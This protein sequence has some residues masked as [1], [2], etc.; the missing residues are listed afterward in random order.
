MS[1]V[2]VAYEARLGRGG[3]RPPPIGRRRRRRS[4][5][6]KLKTAIDRPSRLNIVYAAIKK[7]KK[8]VTAEGCVPFMCF[9]GRR[10]SQA[11]ARA[12]AKK[13]HDP[14]TKNGQTRRRG[15]RPFLR[16]P[17]KTTACR[18]RRTFELELLAF[19]G[20]TA[21]DTIT[22]GRTGN[23]GR[24]VIDSTGGV[25]TYVVYA[26][27]LR[28][29]AADAQEDLQSAKTASSAH[30]RSSRTHAN[31]DTG[32]A[33]S[34]SREPFYPAVE[35]SDPR[36]DGVAKR[37]GSIHRRRRRHRHHYHPPTPTSFPSSAPRTRTH[38]N[39]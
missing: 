19:L 2:W 37:V 5:V 1:G 22:Y 6:R 32:S 3:R 18:G 23:A 12:F 17:L 24:A 15:E 30:Q 13:K 9:A 27:V 7:K 26:R 21:R 8:S 20:S 33:R 31:N 25:C 11:H 10:S 14:S 16:D 4:G 29:T 35:G 34:L 38:V 36:R 39:A 28:G